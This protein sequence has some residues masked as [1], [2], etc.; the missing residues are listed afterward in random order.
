[1]GLTPFNNEMKE[2]KY[3]YRITK[4]MY[5]PEAG[6]FE[7]K[8]SAG[9]L[10]KNIKLRPNFGFAEINS[11]PNGAQITMDGIVQSDITPFKSKKLK[12]GTHTINL[13]FPMYHPVTISIEIKDNETA[14][15]DV[16]LNPAFD[17]IYVSTKPESDADVT[18]DG[19]PTNLKTPCLIPKLPDGE[20]TITVRRQWYEPKTIKIK[21]NSAIKS[22]P[23]NI[24]MKPTFGIINITTVKDADVYIDNQKMATGNYSCRILSGLHTFETKKD[25]HTNDSK[26][27]EIQISDTIN[28]TLTPKPITGEIKIVTQPIEAD[29]LLDN[30]KRGTTPIT[31]HNVLI[32]NYTLKL[33]K[34]GY[35]D[36]IKPIA[37]HEN[38]T[39]EIKENFSNVREISFSSKP[40]NAELYIDA[41][42]IGVTTCISNLT[43]G[44]HNIMLKLID[45]EDYI[46]KIDVDNFSPI[47]YDF[48]MRSD[49]AKEV[50]K[51]KIKKKVW[52]TLGAI[53]IAGAGF[54][55]ISA[56]TFYN[57][58]K[59]ATT[60][61]TNLHKQVQI[62]DMLT[63][64]LTGVAT[65]CLI[66]SLIN[67]AKQK[68]IQR[69]IQ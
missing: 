48:V 29:I 31:L 12:S 2:G 17:D 63:Y 4:D 49:L 50:E 1:M 40:I 5:Y 53:S 51:Y 69:K 20:H 8:A 58:Y 57:N 43:L 55:A 35:A 14:K 64:S 3:N 45:Y 62:C 19:Q 24:A 54:T 28:I 30:E 9:K 56:N 27:I 68:K 36:I 13:N 11:T 65:V 67:K 41:K 10:V 39:T 42:Y 18:V 44:K 26:K 6:T 32:G 7:L 38:K 16:T 21:I 23:V 25:K 33:S 22:E 34:S 66:T 15:I 47:S 52:F 59:T 61:A 46:T 37:V 60:D